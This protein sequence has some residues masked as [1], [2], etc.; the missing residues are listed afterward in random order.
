MRHLIRGGHTWELLCTA[1]W[2]PHQTAAA[3]GDRVACY[4][5]SQLGM[6]QK[7]GSIARGNDYKLAV[8]SLAA[9]DMDENFPHV[10]ASQQK[11]S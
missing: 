2:L 8:N 5:E 6:D 3:Y 7:E 4:C 11:E 1:A 9:I 10:E